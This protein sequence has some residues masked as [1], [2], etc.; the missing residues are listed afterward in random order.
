M[1]SQCRRCYTRTVADDIPPHRLPH[2]R[3]RDVYHGGHT[4][5]CRKHPTI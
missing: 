5:A 1:G 2:K 4:R 3:I